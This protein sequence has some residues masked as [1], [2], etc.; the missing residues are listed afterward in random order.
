V[1]RFPC[2]IFYFHTTKAKQAKTI[3]SQALGLSLFATRE[4]NNAENDNEPEGSLSPSTIEAK[5]LRTTTISACHCLLHLRKKP[6][7]DDEPLIV[8][9]N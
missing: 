9:Y 3:R 1:H 6:R 5:Q 7:D 4:E 2:G 8:F